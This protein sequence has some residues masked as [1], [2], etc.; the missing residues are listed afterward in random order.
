M[1]AVQVLLT[2]LA[3][4]SLSALLS[5]PAATFSQAVVLRSCSHHRA[6]ILVWPD[7]YQG[8]STLDYLYVFLL[9]LVAAGCWLVV[10]G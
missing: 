1:T 6:C 8:S 2:I 7:G 3:V 4:W 10:V 5:S 9:I